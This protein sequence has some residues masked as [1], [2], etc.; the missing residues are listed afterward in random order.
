MM[1]DDSWGTGQWLLMSLMMFV[2]VAAVVTL[3]VWLVRELGTRPD[4]SSHGSAVEPRR[5][6][7]QILA[8]RFARGEID[9]DEYAHSRDVLGSHRHG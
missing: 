1:Y 2:V 7:E 8:E 5:S 4:T 3:T 9:E 6:P